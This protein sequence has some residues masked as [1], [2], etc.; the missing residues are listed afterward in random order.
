MICKITGL[1]YVLL[2]DFNKRRSFTIRRNL[3][4]SGLLDYFRKRGGS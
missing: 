3:F 2:A 1:T 4:L